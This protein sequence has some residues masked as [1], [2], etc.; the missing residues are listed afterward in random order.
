MLG[1]DVYNHK[2]IWSDVYIKKSLQW[3]CG[4]LMQEGKMGGKRL[5]KDYN[6]K[7]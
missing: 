1:E 4:S 7:N 2:I 3:Q 5:V 6:M